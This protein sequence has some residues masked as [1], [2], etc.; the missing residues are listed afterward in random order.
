MPVRNAV[1][2]VIDTLRPDHL[3]CHGYPL[4]TSPHIDAFAQ[5]A[6]VFDQAIA[7]AIPTMPSF[8]T[9]LTG[10]HPYRHGIVSHIPPKARLAEA[11]ETF[12]QLAR[13]AGRVTVGIDNLVVQ[14][15]G[16][17]D[18]FARGFDH[19]SGYLY[20]PFEAQSAELVDR[21]IQYIDDLGH[22]PFLLFL[23]LWDPHTPYGPPPPFDTLHYRSGTAPYDLAE[24]KAIQPEYYERFLGEMRLRHPDDYADVV[25]QYDG[26]ISRVDEQVG[27]LLSHLQAE[28]RFDDTVV[29]VMSDH[30][31]CFGEGGIHFDHHGLV[32]ATVRVACMLRAPGSVPGRVAEMV[33]T[34]DL[35]PTL[36]ALCDWPLPE[37]G[38]VEGHDL[39]PALQGAPIPGRAEIF[40]V[41]STRQASL[42]L[43]TPDW[44]LILPIVRDVHGN[45]LPDLHGHARSPE[46]IL[47]DLRNDP[48]ET[49]DVAE[50]YTDVRDRM[51]ARLAEW[52][53]TE[54]R[55]RGG[56][57]PV[58]EQ[59]LSLGY[60]EFMAR[61]RKRS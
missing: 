14:G 5:S 8:T 19:Y 49:V 29:A 59:A 20:R 27:R 3:G 10:L 26:E 42:A 58:L 12:P 61:M 38:S 25:A 11:V 52:R 2:V 15:M 4:P 1:V 7:P 33:S 16:R 32:D 55:R 18:W 51:L 30:G 17:G 57:D 36:A 43:R 53:S 44:K 47:H 40:C 24:V 50:R 6:V 39:S 21:A 54:V 9:L 22:R 34:E 56:S 37:G 41:E 48:M 35:L 31:E 23:H 46:P 60:D 28:G 13:R 45:P